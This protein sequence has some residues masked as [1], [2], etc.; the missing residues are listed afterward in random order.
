VSFMPDE[1]GAKGVQLLREVAPSITRVG[2]LYAAANPGALVVVTETERRSVQL[3]LHFLRL[4]M[5]DP[6]DL[7]GIFQTA[8]RART[9]ALFVMDDGAMTK[10]R[11]QVADLAVRH[12]LALV[13][14][15]RDFVD[16]G[17]F[18]AYGPSLSAVYRRGAV[19]VDRILKGA[20]PAELP[21]EL[22]TKFDFAINL[23]TAR[24]LNL[25][26][27]PALLLR[28]DHVVE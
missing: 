16:A 10:H 22:P 7:P 1:V 21:V 6:A 19:Y 2:S 8:T 12:S 24:A 25:A 4:P 9:E 3:G 13:S 23:K 28:A 18:I 26:I 17:G 27:P 15:Y 5:R 11:K 20:R 14:V